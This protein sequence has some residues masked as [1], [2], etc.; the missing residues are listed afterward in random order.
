MRRERL[1]IK[2][3]GTRL[4]TFKHKDGQLEQ[5]VQKERFALFDFFANCEYF[6]EDFDYDQKI[7]L[8]K[9]GTG[10]EG[11]D[12]DGGDTGG[13]GEIDDTFHNTIPDPLANIAREPIG[14]DGMRI[15]REM[16]RERFAAQ[17]L[18]AVTHDETLRDAVEAEDW[19]A[20]EAI[21]RQTL[22][23]KS[24]DFWNLPRLRDLYRT[25]R[26]PSL[27]EILQVILGHSPAI[28]N[29]DQLAREHFQHFLDTQPFD[30]TQVRELSQIFQAC[31][32]SVGVREC[33]QNK[34]FARL[35]AIN[36]A[37]YQSIR[38][39][40][41]E[42]AAAVADFVLDQVPSESLNVAA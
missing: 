31:V 35:S 18:A 32:L 29:R 34:D 1:Q 25:D 37:V 12:D 9:I 17:T 41:G 28:A 20:V 30:P 26:E 27:R 15:E 5:Q 13:G 38:T 4:W 14:N 22:F 2:G 33:I 24:E 11:D 7:K 23:D 42:R 40:G 39:V 21:I 16:Y 6:E 8:P 36:T 19:S 10:E 3:R